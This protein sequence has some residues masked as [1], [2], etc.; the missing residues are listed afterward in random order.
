M[1]PQARYRELMEKIHQTHKEF[2]ESFRAARAFSLAGTRRVGGK[3]SYP[4]VFEANRYAYKTAEPL[5]KKRDELL[6][7]LFEEIPLKDFVLCE[8]EAIDRVIDFIE[9]D[10]PA[11][12]CGYVKEWCCSRLKKCELN[13]KQI[14]RLQRYT[15]YLCESPFY[16]RELTALG[17]LMIKLADDDFFI[18]LYALTRH[19]DPRIRRKTSRVI[20]KIVQN[21]RRLRPLHESLRQSHN[22]P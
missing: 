22:Q 12:H 10:I 4:T 1:K 9:I 14:R 16:R 21:D 13:P 3:R 6:S 20:E 15:L 7:L 8:S 19:D 17:L 18:D 2:S 11:F 5:S